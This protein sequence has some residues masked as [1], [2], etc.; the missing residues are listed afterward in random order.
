MQVVLVEQVD[1]VVQ[2]ALVEQV[3][4]AKQVLLV[5]QVDPVDEGNQA[6]LAQQVGLMVG[7]G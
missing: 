6:A 5:E 4:L 2:V 7:E 1:L 3:D